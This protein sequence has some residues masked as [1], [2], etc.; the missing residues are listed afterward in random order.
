VFDITGPQLFMRLAALLIIAAIHGFAVAGAAYMLGDSGPKHD[1]RLTANPFPHI[2]LLGAVGVVLFSLGW[3]RPVV[4]D[5]A[6]L[7]QGRLGL[8]LVPLAGIAATLL[9]TVVLRLLRVPVAEIVPDSMA[10]TTIATLNTAAELSL[11]FVLFNI[12]PIPPLTGAHWLAAAVP[13]LRPAML[14]Y[15]HYVAMLLGVLIVTGVLGN[16]MMPIYRAAAAIVLDPL[17]Y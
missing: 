3:I 8:I 15:H 17:A 12:V 4:V 9:S 14:R 10:L 13:T 5:P 11:W 6:A 2:D 7:R 16:A 1:R